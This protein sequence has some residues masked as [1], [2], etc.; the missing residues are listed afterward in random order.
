MTVKQVAV[1][2]TKTVPQGLS[3][4]LRLNP[5]GDFDQMVAEMKMPQ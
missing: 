3:A 1:I 5:E 2:P 4:M